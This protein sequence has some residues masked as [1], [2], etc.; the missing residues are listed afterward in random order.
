METLKLL[1]RPCPICKNNHGNVLHTQH[2]SIPDKSILP[3]QYD[4]VE[5]NVCGFCFADTTASQESYDTY[6]NNMSKYEDKNTGTG[7]GLSPL[8]KQRMETVVNLISNYIPTKNNSI[9]DIGCANGGMLNCFSEKGFS[10]LIGIDISQKC[11]DNVK[12]LGFDSIFGG[13]FT[14]DNLKGKQFDCLI[15]SHV[16]E[17]ICDLEGASKN[18]ASLITYEGLIYIEVPDA[19]RYEQH[20]FV[21]YYYFDCEHINHFNITALKNLFSK[22]SLEC[23][24]YEEKAILVSDDKDYPVLRAVFR[25]NK[26]KTTLDALEND[27]TVKASINKYL[28][29]SKSHSAFKE[30]DNLI[31]TNEKILVWGAGMYTLRLLQDSPLRKCNILFFIDKDSNKQGNK[32]NEI[33][34]STPEILKNY[35]NTPIIIASA[36]HS[37]AIKDEIVLMD[38]NSKRRTIIL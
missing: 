6:Y 11:V 14:L 38:G 34:I 3:S 24:Y 37:K 29:L 10:N 26:A 33:S 2:F 27:V 15:V 32:I 36:I 17:H 21:P 1:N 25:K 5:C 18:L 7:T 12:S 13:I 28:E 9:V 16:M 22:Q 35:S 20:Y 30:L 8:D 31:K 23:V 19:S 4:V